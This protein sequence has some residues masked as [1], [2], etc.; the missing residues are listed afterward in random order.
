M[1]VAVD[2]WCIDLVD[3][4]PPSTADLELLTA[5][6][7]A[8]HERFLAAEPARIFATT[9]L[10]LRRLLAQRLGC[11]SGDLRIE[12]DARGKPFLQSMPA[13]HFNVSHAATGALIAFCERSPV[14]IDVEG[15]ALLEAS[16]HLRNAI[17]SPGEAAWLRENGAVADAALAR[18]WSRKEAALKAIGA[19]LTV[20]M[21]SFDLGDPAATSGTVVGREM[22]RTLWQDLGVPVAPVAAVAVVDADATQ[23]DLAVRI[24]AS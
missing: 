1:R 21:S 23:V 20:S 6:E 15:R 5:Q 10:A 4:P 17:A 13:L 9:R 11:R 14:G 22:P 3:A 12:V 24:D 19:G 18:L 7:R 16:P 8:R 2:V